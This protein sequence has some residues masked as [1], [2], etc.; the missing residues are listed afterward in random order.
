MKF[1]LAGDVYYLKAGGIF[2]KFASPNVQYYLK[3]CSDGWTDFPA[4]LPSDR[5]KV[6]RITLDKT[7]G[8]KVVIHCNDD[9]VLRVKL[10]GEVCD[11][12]WRHWREYWSRDV[13]HLSFAGNDASDFYRAHPQLDD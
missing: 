7:S 5:N 6:W 9:E 1:W 11:K 13:G 4:S 8:V 3:Q 2:L 10:S 12:K